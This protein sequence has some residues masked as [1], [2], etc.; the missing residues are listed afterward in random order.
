MRRDL[1]R[2]LLGG[3]VDS[4]LAWAL[5]EKTDRMER[6]RESRQWAQAIQA[7]EGEG[8]RV[9]DRPTGDQGI[10][11]GDDAQAHRVRAVLG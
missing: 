2:A 1:S 5:A 9:P 7:W 6:E 8:G 11:L 3:R 4:A 10:A